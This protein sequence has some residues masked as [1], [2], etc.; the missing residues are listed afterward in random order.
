[1]ARRVPD[2]SK[3]RAGDRLPPTVDLDEIIAR[4]IRFWRPEDVDLHAVAEGNRVDQ[5][6][7]ADVLAKI[8]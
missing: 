3:D 1:M 5:A 4:T 2:V 6:V 8:A 7:D